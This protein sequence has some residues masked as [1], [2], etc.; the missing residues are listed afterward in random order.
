MANIVYP[1]LLFGTV[2]V[3]AILGAGYVGCSSKPEPSI[4]CAEENNKPK[5]WCAIK[6]VQDLGRF[7]LPGMETN[8][9]LAVLG[10]PRWS[11]DVGD[12]KMV[13]HHR[14]LPL[15]ADDAA[16]NTNVSVIGVALDL[17]NGRLASWAC[18]YAGLPQDDQIRRERTLLGG[19]MGKGGA[20]LR[21]FVVSPVPIPHGRYVDSVAFPELGYIAAIPSLTIDRVTKAELEEATNIS[22]FHENTSACLLRIAVSAEDAK[23]LKQ[24]TAT[25]IGKR[26][27]VMIGGQPIC[28]P[29]IVAPLEAGSFVAEISDPAVVKT[30]KKELRAAEQQSK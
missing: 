18:I 2:T 15:P 9:I 19:M 13:W 24:M 17:T 11:E 16:P 21:F 14:I 1:S 29:R 25:N 26:V 27:L 6:S 7:L 12:G 3:C 22:G 30:I 8:Q 4:L 20:E 28:A 5:P 10:A 23:L